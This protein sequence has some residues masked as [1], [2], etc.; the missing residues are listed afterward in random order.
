MK[1]RVRN[2]NS[3]ICIVCLSLFFTICSGCLFHEEYLDMPYKCTQ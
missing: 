2:L 3:V 1:N